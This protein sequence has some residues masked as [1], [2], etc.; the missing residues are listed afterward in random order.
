VLGVLEVTI[1]SNALEGDTYRLQVA[2]PSATSDGTTE[3]PLSGGPD[4]T[5]TIGNKG[6]VV[7]DA[8]P[9]GTDLNRD[10]DTDDAGEFGD[11]NVDNIDV[12]ALFNASLLPSVRPPA[13]SDR[14]GAMDAATQDVP[15]SCGGSGAL[16]NNDVVMCLRRSL[17][18]GSGRFVENYERVRAGA[19][20]SARLR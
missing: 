6:F 15:P 14:F 12:V 11:G 2:E 17:L 18:V 9:V 3:L 4:G 20:C 19:S 7:C 13:A 5:L 1:P 10:G 8:M 16:I